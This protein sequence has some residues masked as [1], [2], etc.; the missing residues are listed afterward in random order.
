MKPYSEDLRKAAISAYRQGNK[1]QQE[2]AILFGV[3]YNSLKNWLRMDEAGKEQ[4]SQGKGHRPRLLTPAHLEILRNAI[5]KNPSL[6]I[7]DLVNIVGI[8]CSAGVYHRA[9]KQLGFSY[10][11]NSYLPRNKPDQI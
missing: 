1:S 4:K 3:H 5:L 6:T 11:K 8:D 9:L 2:I 10:K 7:K